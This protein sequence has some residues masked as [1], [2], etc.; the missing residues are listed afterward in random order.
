MEVLTSL[1][2]EAP[3]D[4]GHDHQIYVPMSPRHLS[5]NLLCCQ[6]TPLFSTV[7]TNCQCTASVLFQSLNK[8]FHFYLI[9]QGFASCETGAF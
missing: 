3:L 2:F 7:V 5:P 8:V 1:V 4:W 6:Q 9:R